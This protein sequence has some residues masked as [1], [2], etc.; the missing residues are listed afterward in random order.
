MIPSNQ[1]F[2]TT[3]ADGKY[4][5]SDFYLRLAGK[6]IRMIGRL[7][8][9]VTTVPIPGSLGPVFFR[10]GLEKDTDAFL[11]W[12]NTLNGGAL[13]NVTGYGATASP[14]LEIVANEEHQKG[15]SA[16]RVQGHD[17]LADHS[18][19]YFQA[20]AV[21]IPVTATT[22]LKYGFMPKDAKG[23]FTSIDL[24]MTDG[25]TLRDA[26]A[27]TTTGVRMHP[28]SPKGTVNAWTQIQSDIGTW[29][30]GKTIAKV[31]VAYDQASGTGDFRAYFDNIEI[32]G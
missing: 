28:G 11:T 12:V 24:V 14:R 16:L 15:L 23:R 19:A 18:Y 26:G 17:D 13:K 20:F 1:Y 30:K 9:L 27:T 25:T 4:L 2:Q 5:S 10:T 32:S 8:P 29:L 7:D 22:V 31:L 21:N 6:A 3:S